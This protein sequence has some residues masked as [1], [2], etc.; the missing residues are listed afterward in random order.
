MSRPFTMNFLVRLARTVL[1]LAAGCALVAAETPRQ[2]IARAAANDD[3]AQK[4]ELIASLAGRADDSIAPLLDAWRKD[5]L[6]LFAAPDGT[7]I[8]IVL[9]GDKDAAGT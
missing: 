3:T 2:V 9:N 1:A 6:Y 4:R 5:A 7:R 8:P